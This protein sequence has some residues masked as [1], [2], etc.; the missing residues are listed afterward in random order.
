M[1]YP[2][3]NDSSNRLCPSAQQSF[4]VVSRCIQQTSSTIRK[5]QDFIL[6]RGQVIKNK[7]EQKIK[8]T[9]MTLEVSKTKDTL[10]IDLACA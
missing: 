8:N 9:H 10:I 4:Y 1:F 5:W 6:R 2:G 7:Q 3:E